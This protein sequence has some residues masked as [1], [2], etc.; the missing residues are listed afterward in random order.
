MDCGERRLFGLFETVT[1]TAFPV[2]FDPIRTA[3]QPLDD[4]FDP[5]HRSS[6][7]SFSEADLR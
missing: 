5:C 6:C 1:C 3:M 4:V 7:T 2:G